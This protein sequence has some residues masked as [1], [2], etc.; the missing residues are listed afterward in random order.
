MR[1]SPTAAH[2]VFEGS[3]CGFAQQRL[4]LGEELLDGVEI[5]TIGRQVKQRG[6]GALDG[7][8][9]WLALVRAEIVH[10]DDVADRQGGDE[11][12]L[13]IGLERQPVDR[14]VDHAGGGDGITAQGGQEGAGLPMA[15]RYG[16][17]RP[18]AERGP[19]VRSGEC[20]EYCVRAIRG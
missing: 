5:G 15:M 17:G 12:L 6:T 19:T 7:G 10:D 4:E 14:A 16:A 20:Q 18:L 8:A 13:D 2:R 11:E 9:H 3:G 1:R